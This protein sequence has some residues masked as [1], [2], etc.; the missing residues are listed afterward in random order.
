[1]SSIALERVLSQRNLGSGAFRNKWVRSAASRLGFDVPTDKDAESGPGPTSILLRDTEATEDDLN[2]GKSVI[3]RFGRLCGL[4]SSSLWFRNAVIGLIVFNSVWI[5]IDADYSDELN[6]NGTVPAHTIDVVE[7][8]V[9]LLFLVELSIRMVSHHPNYRLFFYKNE[10]FQIFNCLDFVTTV[11]TI[12]DDLILDFCVPSVVHEIGFFLTV[13]AFRLLRIVKI[14]SMVPALSF[15]AKALWSALRSVFATG[16]ILVTLMYIYACAFTEWEEDSDLPEDYYKIHFSEV[17]LSM[18]SMFELAV[19]D[20][21]V[22][23]TRKTLDHSLV[24]ALLSLSFILLGGF[25]IL[26]VLIGVIADVVA[27]EADLDEARTLIADVDEIFTRIDKDKDGKVSETEFLQ[28]GKPLLLKLDISNYIVDGII[29]IIRTQ[30]I[31]EKDESKD[32]LENNYIT[33]EEFILY[34]S[35]MLSPPS[36]E[37]LLLINKKIARIKHL[38]STL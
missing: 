22:K 21:A 10:Q 20:E 27:Q 23:Q 13:R 33:R 9:G 2:R 3:W 12:I 32:N 31:D 34:M 25:L 28:S 17:F 29:N 1:M 19:Y 24:M 8:V 5:G 6:E 38:Y 37:D 30:N 11:L 15:L 36:S 35:K 4:V 16:V 7:L 26:N 14:F 18:L